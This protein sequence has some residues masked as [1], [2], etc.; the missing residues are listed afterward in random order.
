MR[1][2]LS[3]IVLS[4]PEIIIPRIGV[5]ERLKTTGF[6]GDACVDLCEIEGDCDN[7]CELN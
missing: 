4:K 5:P 1:S 2:V 3:G 7:D 6:S